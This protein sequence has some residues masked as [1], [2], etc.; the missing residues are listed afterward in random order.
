[1]MR[2]RLLPWNAESKLLSGSGFHK[3]FTKFLNCLFG[4][5][6][7][8]SMNNLNIGRIFYIRTILYQ[9]NRRDNTQDIS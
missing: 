5:L 4:F 6:M 3:N 7:K 8:K 9:Y 1:M 2:K